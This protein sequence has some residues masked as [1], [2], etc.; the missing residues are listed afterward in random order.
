MILWQ[1]FKTIKLLILHTVLD[2][3]IKQISKDNVVFLRKNENLLIAY[4]KK[5]PLETT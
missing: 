2:D 4:H 3:F 5:S 1:Q